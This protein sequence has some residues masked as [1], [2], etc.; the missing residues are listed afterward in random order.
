MPKPRV[1]GQVHPVEHL[2]PPPA[3]EA[4]QLVD[5]AKFRRLEVVE[6]ADL[7]PTSAW[8]PR[9]GW[10]RDAVRIEI[11]RRD[12]PVVDEREVAIP[13]A[14]ITDIHREARPQL[15]LDGR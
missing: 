5:L 3:R 1:Q 9:I 6:P 12:R 11:G 7:I 13:G 15:V 10:R 8:Q 2:G 14:E 4:L